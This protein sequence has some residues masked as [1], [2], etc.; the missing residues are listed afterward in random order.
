MIRNKIQSILIKGFG[1]YEKKGH[2][3]LENKHAKVHKIK[4]PR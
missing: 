2:A 1:F 3:T 4:M